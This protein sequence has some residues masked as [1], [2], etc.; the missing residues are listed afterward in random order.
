MC[1]QRSPRLMLHMF[2]SALQKMTKH[3][4]RSSQIEGGHTC[5]T[6]RNYI[7]CRATAVLGCDLNTMSLRDF[8]Q[9]LNRL[10]GG[11]DLLL[12]TMPGLTTKSRV[13]RLTE[14]GSW[15]QERTPT[16]LAQEE[17]KC[18]DSS[19]SGSDSE[20]SVSSDMVR[21]YNTK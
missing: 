19:A 17:D 7:E 6:L 4:N 12:G 11:Q 18:V 21:S 1:T 9:R 14:K 13:G 3:R 2:C 8:F 15:G 10:S 16:V 20:V 5:S